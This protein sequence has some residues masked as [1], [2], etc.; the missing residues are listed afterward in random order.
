MHHYV[1][2]GMGELSDKPGV[3]KTEECPR[4][5]FPLAECDCTDGQHQSALPPDYERDDSI[6]DPHKKE[7]T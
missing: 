2:V 7:K 5:G 3:C 6:K 1:C 4:L